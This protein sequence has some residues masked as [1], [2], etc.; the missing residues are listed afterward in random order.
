MTGERNVMPRF[1]TLAAALVVAALAIGC[2]KKVTVSPAF[3][4]PEGVP[5]PG[6]QLV[7]FF[8]LPNNLIVVKDRGRIGAVDFV[9]DPDVTDS[10]N[11]DPDTGVPQ[12]FPMQEFTPGT[13]RGVIINS[14]TA[15]GLEL[16]RSSASGGLQRVF[17]YTLKP[18]RRFV[19]F[20][21]E[22]YQFADTDPRRVTGANYYAR[23][24]VGGVGGATSP[25]SN[26]ASP[27][28]TSLAYIQYLANR[29]G[30]LPSVSG[31]PPP[32]ESTFMMKWT[33]VPGA[34]RYWIHVF[35][36]LPSLNT[37]QLRLIAGAPALLV[38]A[39]VKDIFVG[40]VPASIT[41]YKLGDPAATIFAYRTPHLKAEYYVRICAVDASNE[42]IGMTTGPPIHQTADLRQI[43]DA[44]DYF[45]EFG[46]G[47]TYLLY[48]R[49]AVRVSPGE[50][51]QVGLVAQ[52]GR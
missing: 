48:T 38:P 47:P 10:I 16:F 28:V 7:T 3:T 31:P 42:I 40:F 15:E 46:S 45:T 17:D 36:N 21:S 5:S 4:V 29:D 39:D 49:G 30:T 50:V 51:A 43:P 13:V 35:Q 6:L 14:T 22:A 24:L 8:D 1:A 27:T 11:I 32:A 44:R 9:Q 34:A 52:D 37:T 19:D 33:P 18:D 25:L 2:A 12:I 41:Q 23:G 26:P 20:T